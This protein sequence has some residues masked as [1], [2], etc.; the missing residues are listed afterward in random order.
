GKDYVLQG[1]DMGLSGAEG[2]RLRPDVIIQLPDGKH[3]IIDSKVSLTAYDRYCGETDD[4]ARGVLVKE[5]LRSAKA[6][7]NGL[8]EKRYQDIDKLQT[9]DFVMMFMPIEGAYS[10]AMQQD[11][12]LHAYAWGKRVVLVCPTTLFATLQTVASLWRIEKA[13]KNA[14]EI[15]KRAGLLYDRF[16][17]FIEDLAKMEG[18][19]AGLQGDYHN[20][21]DRLTKKTGNLLWQVDQL[22]KL[23]AKTT[24][25]VP[26]SMAVDEGMALELIEGETA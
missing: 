5:F 4:L 13:N 17:T 2:H 11:T 23:G 12:E 24:R 18:K 6:H 19:I 26:A 16:M 14:E 15:A 10:L 9:P 7:I 21:M 22:K 1:S 8:A 25:S 3:I 20:A